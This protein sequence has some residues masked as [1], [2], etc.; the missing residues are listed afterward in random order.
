MKKIAIASFVLVAASTSFAQ[1]KMGDI[2]CS[3]YA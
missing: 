2:R 1:S 3:D